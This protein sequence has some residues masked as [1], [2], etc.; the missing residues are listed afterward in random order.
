MFPSRHL[1]FK[2]LISQLASPEREA[3]FVGDFWFCGRAIIPGSQQNW[4][5]SLLNAA[6]RLAATRAIRDAA[7]TYKVRR[8]APVVPKSNGWLKDKA[9]VDG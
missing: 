4:G 6:T 7:S 3:N 5:A 2:K 8:F 1:I 9:R